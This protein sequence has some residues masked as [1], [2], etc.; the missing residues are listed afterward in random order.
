MVYL[1]LFIM[2]VYKIFLEVVRAIVMTYK[3]AKRSPCVS[4]RICLY[5]SYIADI[6]LCFF[7]VID[8]VEL[9]QKSKNSRQNLHVDMTIFN[10]RQ[11][12]SRFIG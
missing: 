5:I 1:N 3:L 2:Y 6:I 11:P 4:I 8:V 10:E 9:T 12:A 7:W